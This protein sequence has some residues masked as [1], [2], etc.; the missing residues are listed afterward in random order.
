ASLVE[1]AGEAAAAAF[2]VEVDAAVITDDA[3]GFVSPAADPPPPLLPLAPPPPALD[4]LIATLSEMA[5]TRGYVT[6]RQAYALLEQHRLPPQNLETTR[7]AVPL[8]PMEET[9][10]PEPVPTASTS[11]PPEE[12]DPRLWLQDDVIDMLLI[13]LEDL[14]LA[15]RALHAL[16]RRGF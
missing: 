16:H 15:N 8:R 5:G 14:R 13:P 12:D 3:M 11:A 9:P 4:E 7:R 2:L 6:E 1:L 10:E